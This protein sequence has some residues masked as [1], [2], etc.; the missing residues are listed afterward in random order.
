MGK[1]KS[2]DLFVCV[3]LNTVKKLGSRNAILLATIEE[4]GE[5]Y[6]EG[7]EVKCQTFIQNHEIKKLTGFSKSGIESGLRELKKQ[8]VV[9]TKLT[10][11]RDG[12]SRR[13]TVL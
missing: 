2:G 7:G 5:N 12:I 13:I 4:S 11:T 10:H 6:S 8:R 1:N 9:K 3:S